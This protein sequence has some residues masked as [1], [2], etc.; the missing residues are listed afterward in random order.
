V[1]FPGCYIQAAFGKTVIFLNRRI[2]AWGSK[3]R[4][5]KFLIS[6]NI[7]LIAFLDLPEILEPVRGPGCISAEIYSGV[8]YARSTQ[9][10]GRFPVTASLK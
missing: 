4:P 5:P 3:P 9:T 2:L 10:F 1:F 8:L 7:N 6:F